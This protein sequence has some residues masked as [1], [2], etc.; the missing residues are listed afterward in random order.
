MLAVYFPV[1]LLATNLGEIKLITAV[2]LML[3]MLV[4][5]AA[6][7]FL[8]QLFVRDLRKASLIV[9]VLMI[10]FSVYG[11][12]YAFFKSPEVLNGLL[13]RHRLLAGMLVLM[14]GLVSWAVTR[15]TRHLAEMTLIGNL[16]A[17]Y[18]LAMP[19]MQITMFALKANS[20]AVS[21]SEIE[22]QAAQTALDG[23]EL[24]DIYYI[25][26]DAYDR[27]DY[28]AS[29][30][31]FDNS[32]FLDHLRESGFYV[33]D[34]SRSNYA[35][36]FL[37]ISSALNMDYVQSYMTE[38]TI[39]EFAL[40]D[41]LVHSKLREQLRALGYQT[42]AFD[43]V[44]WEFSDADVFYAFEIQPILNP[45]LFP[46][47]SA[48]IDN[49][50]LKMAADL[51]PWFNET[52]QA[53][54]SSAVRDHYLQQKYILD[55]MDTA[56]RLDSPKFV[57]VHIEKP[58]GPY[59]F[60]PDGDFIEED[61]FYRDMYHAAIN[62]DYDKRGYVKQIEYLNRRMMT[63]VDDLLASVKKDTIV[64]IQGDHGIQEND[65]LNARM[66]ILNAVYFPD[67]DYSSFYPSITPINTFRI[68]QDQFFSGAYGLLEDASYY[69]YREDK[70]DYFLVE[71]HMAGC[72]Q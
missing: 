24:P 29:E 56:V 19:L 43:N 14:I 65:D 20:D 60:E 52:V 18:L 71:E 63:F 26:L 30:F 51:S 8:V 25:I 17:M 53:L 15:K 6:A 34:C 3:V 37:S 55:T 4:F 28:L 38:E 69:S 66:A 16:F 48:F 42:A 58:H 40:K 68:I 2:R 61:A 49:S 21:P 46:V 47:E 64:I 32:P 13:G 33:A 9:S 57:F 35:H 44:H 7:L 41:A 1:A 67:E 12:I 10:V 59:V 70:M 11:L 5:S 54:A 72:V 31:E 22:G 23:Q 62:A 50:A 27:Q 45:Y 39:S 36:T